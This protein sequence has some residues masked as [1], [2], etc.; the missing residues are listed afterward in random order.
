[1]STVVYTIHS[2]IPGSFICLEM[3]S[4]DGGFTCLPGFSSSPSLVPL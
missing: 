3:G 2:L 4:R 1:M